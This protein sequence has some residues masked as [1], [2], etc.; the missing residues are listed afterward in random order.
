[1]RPKG[2]KA[3][4][5]KIFFLLAALCIIVPGIFYTGRF[6]FLRDGVLN[7]PNAADTSDT[8]DT[9][10]RKAV[11]ITD[12][13]ALKRI[14]TVI[15]GKVQK[16]FIIEADTSAANVKIKPI[17]ALDSIF[18]FEKT[19]SMILRT[20][21][22]AGING[23]FFHAYGQPS[24]MVVID[25]K[26]LS[27]PEGRWPV[28]I[29]C[30][31]GKVY[32]NE[33]D[34]A[35]KVTSGGKCHRIDGV[36]REPGTTETVVYTSEYGTE[37][38]CKT[39]ALNI[40]VQAGVVTAIY[41]TNNPVEIP[42]DGM[43][44]TAGEKR[45]KEFTIIKKSD[46]AVFSFTT[47]PGFGDIESAYQCGSWIVKDGKAALKPRDEWVGLTTNREPRAVIGIKNDGKVVLM[48]VDGRQPGYSAGMNGN[49]LAD[50]LLGYGVDNA[51]MLDGGSSTTMMF[52]DG[53]VNKP[54]FGGRERIVG[55]AIGVYAR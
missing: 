37:T 55:G 32:L 8:S 43:V 26:F 33:L 15:N 40:I 22:Y 12:A 1:M 31:S 36:N 20:G 19:S 11:S 7:G 48:A 4:Y 27:A 23:G 44:I 42:E 53:M 50:F 41:E 38:R 21:A 29:Q 47:N 34:S 45:M 30:S 25:G 2:N 16:I 13:V 5:N 39:N 46:N 6:L 24:G 51:A 9:A 17:L 52:K 18:G 35:M 3:F 14:D 10:G 49:E 54:S 28:F